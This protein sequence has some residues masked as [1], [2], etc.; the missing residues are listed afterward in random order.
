[1]KMV[2]VRFSD[3]QAEADAVVDLGMRVRVFCR[4]GG[5]YELSAAALPLLDRL[6]HGYE[7]LETEG[8]DH[9]VQALRDPVAA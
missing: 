9:L 4:P 2:K 8:F 7:V 3:A 1:M 6:G 5:V